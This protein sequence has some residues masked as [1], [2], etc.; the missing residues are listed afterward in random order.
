MTDPRAKS[1]RLSLLLKQYDASLDAFASR[2]EGL[3]DIELH[4]A[5]GPVAWDVR[6][7]AD[8]TTSLA[9]GK[10]DWL[11]DFVAPEPDPPPFTTIAWRLG[12]LQMMDTLRHDHTFGSRSLSWDDVDYVGGA[13]DAVARWSSAQQQWRAGLATL[14]D[15]DLD[16]VGLSSWPGGLDP[17]VPFGDLLWWTNREL[18]HHAAEIAT[19]RD[20]LRDGTRPLE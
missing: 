7:R 5:P 2:L 10:S 16:T 18:I 12:H 20:L 17:T 14:A 6:R 11:L 13:Q 8:V 9:T 3:S 15:S 1:T 19:I 4:W